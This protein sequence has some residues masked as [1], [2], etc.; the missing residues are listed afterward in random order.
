M[1]VLRAC[2]HRHHAARHAG[3]QQ[4]CKGC[5]S[6]V[7][8]W[9]CA[10]QPP[11]P[12]DYEKAGTQLDKS[13]WRCC[14][15]HVHRGLPAP[16]LIS[17]LSGRLQGSA[18]CCA[19]RPLLLLL[20][21]QAARAMQLCCLNRTSTNLVQKHAQSRT[22][23][24]VWVCMKALA[25]CKVPYLR[26]H[27]L[28]HVGC[29]EVALHATH[30]AKQFS[31]ALLF[32]M[33]HIEGEGSATPA[34]CGGGCVQGRSTAGQAIPGYLALLPKERCHPK[35]RVSLAEKQQSKRRVS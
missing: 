25:V 17:L 6:A 19:I 29:A 5:H 1:T 26:T 16:W 9:L 33:L 11:W 7:L 4:L 30:N 32:S 27:Q 15:G 31:L 8:Q 23:S 12:C 21:G 2:K 13:T 24:R 3:V 35:C 34:V 28:H 18:L 14:S 10:Q 20:P 22:L